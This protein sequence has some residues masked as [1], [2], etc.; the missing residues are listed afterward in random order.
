MLAK[1]TVQIPSK[2]SCRVHSMER[3]ESSPALP[4]SVAILSTYVSAVEFRH[5]QLAVS[6]IHHLK[7]VDSQA[8]HPPKREFCHA[9]VLAAR[10]LAQAHT[11]GGASALAP[12]HGADH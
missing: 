4:E 9:K 8:E 7:G 12:E 6:I 1:H 11:H 5:E 2:R 10:I 3:G